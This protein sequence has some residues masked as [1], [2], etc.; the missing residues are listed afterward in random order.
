MSLYAMFVPNG[1]SGFGYRSTAEEVS[2]GLELSGKNVLVTGCNSGL[3]LETARVLALRGARV[4]GTAR[5]L[6]KAKQTLTDSRAVPLECELSDPRS[7]YACVEAVRAS[8]LRLDAIIANAGIMALPELKQAHGIELQLFTNHIGHFL[9]ITGLLDALSDTGRVVMVSSAAHKRAPSAG[10]ELDNLSGERG[11]QPWRAYGQSKMANLLFAKELARRFADS[12]R[13][14]LAL[15]PG[16][17]ATNLT[18]NVSPL[19]AQ[20]WAVSGP[21]ALKSLGQGA[22]TQVFAA[23]HPGAVG[24]NGA[25]LSD[26]NVAKPRAD[27]N[28]ADLAR[29]LWEASASIAAGLPR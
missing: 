7:V 9:L 10:V 24:L 5:T 22:A 29:R 16:V 28:N 13:I 6:E 15:H 8:G 21:L 4:L 2:Q 26:C 19:L 20:A 18:R 27:A 14:A 3:G 17:I 1:P 25:Y 23:V 11:Y 12:G